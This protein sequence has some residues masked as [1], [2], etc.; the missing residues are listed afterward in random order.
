MLFNLVV[1]QRVQSLPVALDLCGDV[2]ILKDDS[3]QST[4]PPFC[5]RTVNAIVWDDDVSEVSKVKLL[6]CFPYFPSNS[7]YTIDR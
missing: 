3:G 1:R 5:R 7:Q 6:L 4:L 2:F